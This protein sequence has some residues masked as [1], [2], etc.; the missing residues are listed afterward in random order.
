MCLD[1]HFNRIT[2]HCV[3]IEKESGVI[4]AGSRDKLAAVHSNPVE[5]H[6]YQ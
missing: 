3:E 6:H 2:N 4:K 1:L 5:R